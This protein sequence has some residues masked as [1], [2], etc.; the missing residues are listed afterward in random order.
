MGSEVIFRGQWV[1]AATVA[2][3]LML[4]MRA[5]AHRLDEYLQAARISVGVARVDLELDL[6][7]GVTVADAVIHDIDTNRDGRITDDEGRAY[8]DRVLRALTLS[9][10]GR[11]ATLRL[12]HVSVATPGDMR[13]GTGT[14]RL[15]ASAA[16]A[17]ARGRRHLSFANAYRPD[18]GAYL[19]NA[20]VPSDH[21]IALRQQQRD[22]LQRT[23]ALD[24]DVAGGSAWIGWSAA[25][26]A[27]LAFLVLGRTR[28][29]V[30]GQP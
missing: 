2:G 28:T 17:A 3:V 11:P 24:Y 20:L 25:G 14:I 13:E 9:V 15:A 26:L 4:P 19:V 6:S 18:I 5:D 23:Y 8:A 12:E 7:P 22:P 16:I 30:R 29:E 1:A 27:M 10:D 21:R